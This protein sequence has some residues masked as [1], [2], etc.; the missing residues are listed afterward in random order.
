M[1]DTLCFITWLLHEIT[2]PNI[3]FSLDAN[4]GT[5]C[6]LEQNCTLTDQVKFAQH[7][8]TKLHMFITKQTN[9]VKQIMSVYIHWWNCDCYWINIPGY[10]N[11]LPHT[12]LPRL[13]PVQYSLTVQ[14]CGLKPPIISFHSLR[15]CDIFMCEDNWILWK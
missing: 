12:H 2:S 13:S 15:W 3:Y 10:V 1:L 9:C 7:I 6:W 5:F 4:D 11:H 14:N 8:Y